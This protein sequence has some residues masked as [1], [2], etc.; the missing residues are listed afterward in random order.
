MSEYVRGPEAES[1]NPFIRY[2]WL[3]DSYRLAIGRGWSDGDFVSLVDRL[4]QAI[5]GVEGHGFSITP[6][7]RETGLAAAASLPTDLLWVKDDTG[8]VGGSHKARHLFGV[9]LHMAITDDKKGE[10]A[11]ASCGNAALAAAVVAKAADRPLRVFIPTWAEPSV[12][13]RLKK[14]KARIEV[15][16]RRPGEAGDPTY[17]RL[18]E[19]I[20][21][22]AIPFSV[23]GIMTPTTIDGGRTIGW[24]LAEQ[25]ARARVEGTI[26]LFVQV[27]GGAL[28]SAVWQG[29]NDG[30]HEQWL[31]ARPVLHTVQTESV[32]PL[33]R[34]WSRL[35]R[36][37]EEQGV[38]LHED[39]FIDLA[40]RRA[41]EAPEE[42]MWPWEDVQ[43][44]AASGILDDVTYDWL[45]VVEAMLRSRGE[46]HVI[47]EQVVLRAN[48]LARQGTGIRVDPTGSA[49]LGGLLDP[50][51]ATHVRADD[52]VVIFFTGVDRNR[53]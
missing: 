33:N 32:A 21:R 10:L 4:D 51:V 8:N 13:A 23:Q 45:P 34:A 52:N 46:A 26:H 49:G 27:G 44:S 48:D 20:E 28:A 11:I 39:D 1:P 2:R 47:S 36:W 38:G 12:V 14:L 18:A 5:S 15:S 17:L 3:L 43:M 19:A 50:A 41:H 53:D 7:T 40:V 30:I 31:N 25:L 16:E 35:L 24:E 42:F 22:G 6:L 29:V 37:S 9:L